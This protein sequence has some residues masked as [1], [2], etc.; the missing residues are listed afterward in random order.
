MTSANLYYVKDNN[1]HRVTITYTKSP[2]TSPPHTHTHKSARAYT[3]MLPIL[4]KKGGGGH[5]VA[6]Y[7]ATSRKVTSSRPDEVNEFFSIYLILPA[8]LDPGV[9]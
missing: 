8:A 6:Q 1:K 9:Y 2:S 3:K 4:L 5:A 7:Y